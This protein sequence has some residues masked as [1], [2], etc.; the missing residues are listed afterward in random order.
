[1]QGDSIKKSILFVMILAGALAAG[2][3]CSGGDKGRV[4]DSAADPLVR[5]RVLDRMEEI[6]KPAR[7]AAEEVRQAQERKQCD[8][9]CAK[10]ASIC[11][12][13]ARL[14]DL[15]SDY[16][17]EDDEV[18]ERCQW[19]NADCDMSKVACATCGGGESQETEE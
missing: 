13:S 2:W 1:M 7:K 3:G 18:H 8:G 12:A 6:Y 19:C 5:E 10:S 14:C 15:A 17:P 4:R 9:V 16:P 11:D